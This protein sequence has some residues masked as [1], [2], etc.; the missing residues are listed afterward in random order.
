M[1][2]PALVKGMVPLDEFNKAYCVRC[3]QRGCERAG[4]NSS[5]IA[6][7]ARTWK[8][9]LFER[10]PRADNDDPEYDRIRAKRF[11]P[12]GGQGTYEIRAEKVDAPSQKAEPQSELWIP[13]LTQPAEAQTVAPSPASPTAPG[14]RG[15]TSSSPLN[16]PFEQ[17]T[18]LPC[19]EERKVEVGG[20]YVF[21][22][23]ERSGAG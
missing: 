10:V 12:A 9:R 5:L 11:L 17:G 2:D 18:V 13:G 4:M 19:E 20:T 21:G 22:S 3:Q 7:R 16:T 6:V 1:N 14:G 23:D 8:E 15:L